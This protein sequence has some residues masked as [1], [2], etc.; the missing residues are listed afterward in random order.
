MRTTIGVAAGGLFAWFPHFDGPHLVNILPVLAPLLPVVVRAAWQEARAQLPTVQSAPWRVGIIAALGL[1]LIL[2]NI[3]SLRYKATAFSIGAGPALSRSLEWVPGGILG[4]TDLAEEVN[5]TVREVQARSSPGTGIFAFSAASAMYILA[6]RP[7]STRQPY[8]YTW[9]ADPVRQ[10]ETL[11]ELEQ[12]RPQVIVIDK[13]TTQG[14]DGDTAFMDD[15]LCSQ[16]A[17]TREGSRYLV[18]VRN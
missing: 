17:I 13:L 15:W 14:P 2:P 7:M 9:I 18:F 12:A 11:R 1:L 10:Q 5:A 16:Y 8:L 3:G 6:D 4:P